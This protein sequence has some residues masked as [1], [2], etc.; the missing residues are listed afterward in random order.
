MANSLIELG[1]TKG[2]KAAVWSYNVYEVALLNLAFNSIG[3]IC[4]PI[5]EYSTST[6][7]GYALSKCGAKALFMPCLDSLQ[8]ESRTTFHRIFTEMGLDGLPDLKHLIY[9]DGVSPPPSFE[10]GHL[11]KASV[12]Q[13][14]KNNKTTKPN[15]KIS[16]HDISHL[17]FTEG[18]TGLPKLCPLTHF[19]IY[20]V[21]NVTFKSK[22]CQDE[23]DLS[24]KFCLSL[25]FNGIFGTVYGIGLMSYKPIELVLP[26]FDCSAKS[27]ILMCDRYNCTDLIA[28]PLTLNGMINIINSDEGKGLKASHLKNVL[29]VN[30]IISPKVISNFEKTFP[31]VENLYVIYGSTETH[32]LISLAKSDSSSETINGNVCDFTEVKIVNPISGELVK[33]GQ[34]GEI[35]VRG[36]NVIKEYQD[37]EKLTNEYIK[38]DWFYTGDLGT[39]NSDGSINYIIRKSDIITRKGVQFY[40]REVEEVLLTHPNISKAYVFAIQVENS[41][42]EIIAWVT[43]KSS[44][45]KLKPKEVINYCKNKLGEVKCPIRVF[46]VELKSYPFT[47]TGKLQRYKMIDVQSTLD[48]IPDVDFI[49]GRGRKTNLKRIL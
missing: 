41:G 1:L 23:N 27:V 28:T 37:D 48:T 47:R 10:G 7:L 35:I 26:P 31:S 33:N 2:D 8:L 19:G 29:A 42:T 36:Y 49:G 13:M 11:N 21:N 3:V 38:D 46:E 32:G 44:I 20:N 45:L 5:S 12:G 9:M 6:E 24:K 16:P 18:T 30:D 39:M 25:P 22:L 14:M 4:C 17:L 40:A 43:G 15:I 34:M